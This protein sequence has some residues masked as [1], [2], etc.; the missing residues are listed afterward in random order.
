MRLS[1][2][3]ETG[4]I[5]QSCA[6]AV[7]AEPAAGKWQPIR[8]ALAAPAFS[9]PPSVLLWVADGGGK[10]SGCH[11]F[12]RVYRYSDGDVR[13]VASGFSGNWNITHWMPLPEPPK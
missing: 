1:T 3:N 13:A 7:P 10:G 12:G 6:V 11:A 8:T 9:D 2:M 4:N 5:D